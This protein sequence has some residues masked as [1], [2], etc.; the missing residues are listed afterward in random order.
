MSFLTCNF[1]PTAI[2]SRTAIFTP[3]NCRPGIDHGEAK[4]YMVLDMYNYLV[5]TPTF[6]LKSC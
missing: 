1:W 3:K 5:K 4:N 2:D 6:T